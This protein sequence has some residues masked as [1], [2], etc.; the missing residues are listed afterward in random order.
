MPPFYYNHTLP[1]LSG[2]MVFIELYKN[3]ESIDHSEM[4]LHH[5]LRGKTFQVLSRLQSSVEIYKKHRTRQ[6]RE[7]MVVVKCGHYQSKAHNKPSVDFSF[8]H[9]SS[10]WRAVTGT[11][12]NSLQ[13]LQVLMDSMCL[14]LCSLHIT[15][16]WE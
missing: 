8:Q 2:S 4:P 12:T 6:N 7:S 14:T 16:V 5:N 3:L 9:Q 13:H 10:P 11:C 15:H 1:V